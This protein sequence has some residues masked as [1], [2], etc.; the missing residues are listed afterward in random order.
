[1][2]IAIDLRARLQEHGGIP[3][4]TKNIVNHI[5][6]Q[7][8]RHTFVLFT[9]SYSAKRSHTI[10]HQ[11]GTLR[12]DCRIPSKL[13][14]C[15][16]SLVQR[17]YLDMIVQK[18]I[19]KKIDV[20][21]SPNINFTSVSPRCASVVTAHDIS[22]H[23]FPEFFSHKMRVWHHAVRPRAIFQR[24]RHIIAVSKR[25]KADLIST[26][27]VP[28]Q[29]ISVVYHGV[30]ND[31]HYSTIQS[32][33]DLKL[34]KRYILMVGVD[35]RRK[36]LHTLIKAFREVKKEHPDLAD[37]TLIITGFSHRQSSDIMYMGFV[38]RATYL[39]LLRNAA[40]LVYASFYEGFGLPLLEAF[41][42][43]TPVIASAHSSISEIGD[44]AFFPIDPYNS[45]SLV[46]ALTE[47]LYDSTLCEYLKNQGLRRSLKFSW[48]VAARQTLKIF[49]ECN[50]DV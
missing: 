24:A 25:T 32:M 48:D 9:N 31:I 18:K 6:A 19:G 16:L 38:P 43:C 26:Y 22:F 35:S 2:T 39:A 20:W 37:L 17:P 27:T 49:E 47:V 36:N 11:Q 5:L 42:A 10:I 46:H 41:A 1:M 15:S 21:F 13:L 12:V 7:R 8:S 29:K 44:T 50:N 4:Y 33:N 40:V 23:Y 34:P 3:W 45:A 28:E 14:S 30:D